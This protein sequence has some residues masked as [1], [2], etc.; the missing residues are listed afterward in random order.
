MIPKSKITIAYAEDQRWF[1][2]PTIEM[3]TECGFDVVADFDDGVKLLGF[4]E[5]TLIFPDLILTDLEM[6][7]MNGITLTKEILKKWPDSKVLILTSEVDTFY[8]EEAKK[9]GAL[10]FLHKIIDYKNIESALTD[11]YR[12]GRTE[13]GELQK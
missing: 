7:E 13:I 6:P 3:L 1:R 12:E 2:E 11:I 5:N 10:A 8:V 4:L 9:V